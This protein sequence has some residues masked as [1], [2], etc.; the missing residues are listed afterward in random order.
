MSGPHYYVGGGSLRTSLLPDYYIN[1][2]PWYEQLGFS[3]DITEDGESEEWTTYGGLTT[4]LSNIFTSYTRYNPGPPNGTVGSN[5]AQPFQLDSFG[6]LT[7]EYY[8]VGDGTQPIKDACDA[9]WY[10]PS[11][12]II[13]SSNRVIFRSA[14]YAAINALTTSTETVITAAMN[15][16][17]PAYLHF[18]IASSIISII[19]ILFILPTFWG[20]WRLDRKYTHSPVEVAETFFINS[21][22]P[23]AQ[24]RIFGP[25]SHGWEVTEMLDK[26]GPTKVRYQK[27]P[28]GTWMMEK[29]D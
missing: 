22:Q 8:E 3:E 11:F 1:P 20:W 24:W 27:L 14:I 2:T 4:A 10:S 19:A 16:I 23:D 6:M 7:Q 12:E 25:G 28:D 18:A 5:G 21:M 17:L 9:Y 15:E 26:I 29:E 13:D